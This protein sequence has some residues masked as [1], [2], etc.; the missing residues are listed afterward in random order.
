MG[1]D[2]WILL[3]SA[4]VFYIIKVMEII[5]TIIFDWGDTVMRDFPESKGAM[6]YW[7]HVEVVNGAEEALKSM[8]QKF[9]CCLTSN[10]GD[11]DAT[12]M[13][14]ALERINIR[15]YFQYLFTSKELGTKKP[16][17]DFYK[18]ILDKL[19]V[20]PQE[21]VAVG[22]DYEKDIVPA[23]TLGI[24]TIWLSTM[25]NMVSGEKADYIIK[26]M[27]ELPLAIEKLQQLT[28]RR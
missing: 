2:S 25:K 6:V 27:Q 19:N 16:N 12:M 7:P 28:D 5:N 4:G 20:K 14:L 22:N 9:T 1:Q 11:S 17:P 13:G 24:K 18:N 23:G 10:A 26:S 15:Q 8:H 21:C 3:S